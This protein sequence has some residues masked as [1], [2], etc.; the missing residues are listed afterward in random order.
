MHWHVTL[1]LYVADAA[2]QPQRVDFTAPKTQ[3]GHTY[4]DFDSTRLHGGAPDFDLSVHMHQN[5]ASPESGLASVAAAQIHLEDAGRCA[6]LESALGKLDVEAAADGWTL[7]GAHDQVRGQAG[8]HTGTVRWWLQAQDGCDW[9]W[10]EKAWAEVA[11]HQL[12]DNEAVLGSVGDYTAEQVAA[13]QASVPAPSSRL[14][15]ERCGK[16]QP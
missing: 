3:S 9:T 1:G 2:G 12:Q 8:T 6:T 10:N 7:T 15:M 11:G 14:P 16:A 5:Q 13:M 4:Y